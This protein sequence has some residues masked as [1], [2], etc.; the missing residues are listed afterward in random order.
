[1][2]HRARLVVALSLAPAL[3]GAQTVAT[4][5]AAPARSLARPPRPVHAWESRLTTLGLRT[6]IGSAYA[7]GVG[8]MRHLERGWSR[9]GLGGSS[10]LGAGGDVRLVSLDH[11]RLDAVMATA[12]G[13]VSAM[14]CG[15]AGALETGLGLAAD[16]RGASNGG[17]GTHLVGHVG[18][19]VGA[20]WVQ[21]G[22]SYQF[23]LGSDRP[24][25]LSSHQ[26]SVRI[27]IPVGRYDERRTTHAE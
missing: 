3:A 9:G 16:L 1:M 19:L 13:R 2:L 26:F 10:W 20:H 24:E 22:Y 17:T 11:T 21:L 27:E 7:Y 14:G 5:G 6:D 25:W 12:I 8:V 18:V 4:D 23:P 15:G